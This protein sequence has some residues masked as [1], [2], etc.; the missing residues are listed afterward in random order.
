MLRQ[1][2]RRQRPELPL[3]SADGSRHDLHGRVSGEWVEV[4]IRLESTLAL[5]RFPLRM[6]PQPWGLVPALRSTL[7]IRPGATLL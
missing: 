7:E 1:M 5:P 4:A 6:S 3:A 2:A